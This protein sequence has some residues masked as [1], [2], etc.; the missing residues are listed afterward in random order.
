[1]FSWF[2]PCCSNT[3]VSWFLFPR[4]NLLPF[5]LPKSLIDLLT[6]PLVGSLR[7]KILCLARPA[8]TQWY[9]Y[10][11]KLLPTMCHWH[12]NMLLHSLLTPLLYFL[13]WVFFFHLEDLMS[14]LSTS[15]IWIRPD[16]SN[17]V[18]CPCK[19]WPSNVPSLYKKTRRVWTACIPIFSFFLLLSGQ[20]QALT[21]MEDT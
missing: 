1:M 21:L 17:I 7:P 13:K 2:H 3:I 16:A 10:W 4:T 12:V 15:V 18:C 14:S 5:V 8:L 20:Y 9:L 11:R 6:A 19:P